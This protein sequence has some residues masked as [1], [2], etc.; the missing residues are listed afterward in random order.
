VAENACFEMLKRLAWVEAELV[1]EAIARPRVGRQGIHLSVAPVERDHQL[2]PEPL[3]RWVDGGQL[4]ELGGE[5]DVLSACEAK[6]H[7][8]LSRGKAHL[9]ETGGRGLRESHAAQ[10]RQCHAPPKPKAPHQ[11]VPG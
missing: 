2:P 8:V 9:I 10:V 4:L 1:G 7:E 3:P 11:G 6:V 5:L